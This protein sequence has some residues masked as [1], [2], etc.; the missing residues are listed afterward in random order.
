MKPTEI[1]ERRIIPAF[2][3]FVCIYIGAHVAISVDDAFLVVLIS[4]VTCAA[5]LAAIVLVRG[6]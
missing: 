4:I 2:L 1:L 3:A 5:A 6:E